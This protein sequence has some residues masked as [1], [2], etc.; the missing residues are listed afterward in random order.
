MSIE[1]KGILVAFATRYDSTR[2]VAEAVAAELREAG[3]EVAI[4]PAQKVAALNGYRA[5]VL[6][7]PLYLGSWH[8]NALSL[9]ARHQETLQGLRVAVFAL[10]PLHNEQKERQEARAQLEKALAGFPWLAPLSS[11]VFCGRYEPAKLRFGDRLIAR[12]PASPL[13]DVPTTDA[14]D[15]TE[16]RAW[17]RDLAG[18][19]R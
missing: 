17:A 14:R 8:K 1:S 4:Q 10:G 19:L 7:A 5:I 13:H 6:G 18:R 9:L 3:R 15:W 12:L 11:E 2:E 16:I